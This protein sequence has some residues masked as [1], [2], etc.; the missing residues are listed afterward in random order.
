MRKKIQ[1]SKFNLGCFLVWQCLKKSCLH[2]QFNKEIKL[3]AI[4][5]FKFEAYDFQGTTLVVLF[6]QFQIVHD[7]VKV[8]VQ[9]HHPCLLVFLP[10]SLLLHLHL[11]DHFQLGHE[12]FNI[13][14]FPIHDQVV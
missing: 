9:L 6:V 4:N 13:L 2:V 3:D 7:F 14:I 5:A 11:L 10:P 8:V 12:S 1:T